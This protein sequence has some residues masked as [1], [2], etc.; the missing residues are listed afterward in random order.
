MGNSCFP[1]YILNWCTCRRGHIWL[2]WRQTRWLDH[3]TWQ[4]TTYKWWFTTWSLRYILDLRVSRIDYMRN[5]IW[6]LR[7]ESSV[8]LFTSPFLTYCC[9]CTWQ[10]GTT[11]LKDVD[12]FVIFTDYDLSFV[13]DYKIS[14]TEIYKQHTFF[15]ISIVLNTFHFLIGS[16]HGLADKKS[17]MTKNVFLQTT[18]S[19]VETSKAGGVVGSNPS[20]G[21]S[22][23]TTCNRTPGPPNPSG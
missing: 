6:R 23:I 18:M 12:K 5:A 16:L 15:L 19:V 9:S 21:G 4:Q 11:Y 7:S 13:S 1:I 14:S 17:E 2:S 10:K 8:S 20:L 3:V 22:F